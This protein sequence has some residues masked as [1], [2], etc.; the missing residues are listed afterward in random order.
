MESS[1]KERALPL[2]ARRGDTDMVRFLLEHEASLH[3]KEKHSGTPEEVSRSSEVTVI[4]RKLMET[5]PREGLKTKVNRRSQTW[6]LM[7][8]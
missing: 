7:C 5:V 1:F 2:A 4:L 8:P 3:T 6:L